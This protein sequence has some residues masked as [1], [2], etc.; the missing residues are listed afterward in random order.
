VEFA[1]DVIMSTNDFE[2]MSDRGT[3][4][5]PVWLLIGFLVSAGIAIA[6]VARRLIALLR[7]S[8]NALDTTFSSHAGLTLAHIIP[9]A[10]FV[11]L[12]VIVLLRSSVDV[13]CER[14]FFLFGALTGITAYAMSV[15]A[16]GGWVERSAILI[17]NTWF[18]VSLGC[19]YW[20]RKTSSKREWMTRAVG[21]LLGIATT[22]PVM[23]LFFATSAATHLSPEQFF[24]YAFWIGFSINAVMVELWLRSRRLHRS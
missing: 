7:P 9:A 2:Q 8:Q 14:L 1:A 13:W 6:A 12:A 23:G 17:F 22:R 3:G 16:V 18:L 11:V 20:F 4:R 21:I 15:D 19:A 5:R 24:G 10:V